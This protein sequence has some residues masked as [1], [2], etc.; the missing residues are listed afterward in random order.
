M[1][2]NKKSIS[3]RQQGLALIMSLVILL[4]LTLLGVTSMNT[5]NL[6]LLMTSNSQYQTSALNTAEQ[7]II[8]AQ[9]SITNYVAQDTGSTPPVG[10][11]VMTANTNGIDVTEYDW[12]SGN[13]ASVDSNTQYIIEH[14]GLKPLDSASLAWYKLQGQATEGDNVYVYRITARAE[15]SRGAARFLQSVFVTLQE[16]D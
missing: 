6:Q 4:V 3:L 8:A 12:G 11:S 15:T 10:Y 1:R 2:A 7:A 14:A 9:N 13:A 16:P 5:S